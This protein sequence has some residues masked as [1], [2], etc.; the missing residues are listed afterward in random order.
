VGKSLCERR[1]H[2]WNRNPPGPGAR[3]TRPGC[4]AAYGVPKRLREPLP[5]A[6]A[7]P[8]AAP[9]P[10]APARSPLVGD[11]AV[12]FRAAMGLGQTAGASSPPAGT[13]LAA[14]AGQPPPA[15]APP[16]APSKPV[17]WPWVASRLT[18]AFVGACGA[19]VSR[20]G[21]VPND[22]EEKDVDEFKQA[23]SEQLPLWFPQA[24]LSPLKRMLMAGGF[25]AGG[26]WYDAKPKAAANESPKDRPSA[27]PG[28]D[29]PGEQ[30]EAPH[31]R[32]VPSSS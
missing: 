2:K 20:G 8:H 6:P 30:M 27:A 32:P 4:N 24:E 13:P 12:A 5:G 1:L 14:L 23:L 25:I 3:C 22:P 15:P 11:R 17:Q 19:A 28:A 9:A 21:R 7:A 26:M 18:D 31:L 16:A 10:M 29:T